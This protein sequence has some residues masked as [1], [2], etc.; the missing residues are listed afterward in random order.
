[1]SLN[2]KELS[3]MN[4]ELIAMTA[5]ERILWAWDRFGT[6]LVLSTS[7]GLQSA[8]MLKLVLSVNSEIPVVFVDTGY[9]FQETYQY[10]LTLQEKIKF[11]VKTFSAK[12]T[13]AFQEASFGKLW[14][15]GADEMKKYNFINKKEPMERALKELGSTAWFSGL[16]RAQSAD[17]GKRPYIEKQDQIYKIYPILD[18][19]DRKTYQFLPQNNLPY[20]P[21]EGMGYDSLGDFH[22]TH[23][24]DPSKSVEDSRHGGH[25]RECGLHL[26]LPEGLDF[27]V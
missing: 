12:M 1:M 20:H 14:E 16:R 25:G 13:P 4:T 10:S 24:Y 6:G 18:W 23:K 7:F 2:E 27:S 26:D 17:R 19:D 15:Q 21:L 22:S 8:V 3:V 9:L 5:E 11:R